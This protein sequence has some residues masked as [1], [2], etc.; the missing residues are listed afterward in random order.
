MLQETHVPLH[1][2]ARVVADSLFE[3]GQ[4]VEQ[5]AFAGIGIADNRNRRV[6]ALRYG[7]LTGRDT[8]FGAFSHQPLQ[9]QL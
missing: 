1:G 5:S 2:N 7:Y 9:V 8:D 4:A 3:A 6:C